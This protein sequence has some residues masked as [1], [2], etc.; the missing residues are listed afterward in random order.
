MGR[1]VHLAMRVDDIDKTSDFFA[2]VFGF[3]QV[4]VLGLRETVRY[5]TDETVHIAINQAGAGT[6]EHEGKCDHF[7]I[8]VDDVAKCATEAEKYG[9][10]VVTG[11]GRLFKFRAPG[12]IIVEPVPKG[13]KPGIG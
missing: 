9:C 10:E 4:K 3:T 8:E 2:K 7:G 6:G 5:V 13:S 11:N 12:G 1:I